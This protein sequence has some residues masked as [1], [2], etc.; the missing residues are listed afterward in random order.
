MARCLR[1]R[2]R[3]RSHRDV[4]YGRNPAPYEYGKGAPTPR[5]I[6]AAIA[7]T[8]VVGCGSDSSPAAPS[9]PS[10]ASITISVS[11]DPGTAQ[12]SSDPDF[13]WEVE[14]TVT[15]RESA[16]V[17]ATVNFINLTTEGDAVNYGSD[18]IISAAGTNHVNARG[19]LEIPLA[20]FYT[21]TT[22]GGSAFE[23]T[24]VADCTDERGNTI[25]ASTTW[26]VS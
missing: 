14:F 12:A 16:G 25:T 3:H 9:P 24:L 19:S 22:T 15:V 18:L 2:A 8:L 21:S 20:L 1:R 4:E 5:V 23:T 13:V 17:G 10:R 6:I 26:S 11:P 7:L